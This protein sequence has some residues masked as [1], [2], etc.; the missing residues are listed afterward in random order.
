MKGPAGILFLT[1]VVPFGSG[2]ITEMFGVECE[3]DLSH[4]KGVLL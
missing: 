3:A 2:L 1:L 4:K